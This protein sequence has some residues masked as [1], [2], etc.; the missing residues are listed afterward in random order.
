MA[1][2]SSLC[3]T[4]LIMLKELIRLRLYLISD[5]GLLRRRCHHRWYQRRY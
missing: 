2:K 5:L 3:Q 1:L 4:K